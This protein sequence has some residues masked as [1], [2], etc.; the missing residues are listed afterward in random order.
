LR[1]DVG[2]DALQFVPANDL[3]TVSKVSLIITLFLD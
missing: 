2:S 3:S 1:R